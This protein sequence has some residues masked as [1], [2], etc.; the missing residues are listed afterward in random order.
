MSA[1]DTNKGAALQS[2]LKVL[3]KLP[4]GADVKV[5]VKDEIFESLTNHHANMVKP[6]FD[7]VNNRLDGVEERL[8]KIETDVSFVKHDISDIKADLS[9]TPTLRQVNELK[10]KVDKF[11]AS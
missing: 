11:L 8:G 3:K 1:R 10:S 2:I 9:Q 7:K 6:E 4:T 5:V